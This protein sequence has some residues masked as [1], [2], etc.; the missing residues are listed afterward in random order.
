MTE[1]DGRGPL[2]VSAVLFGCLFAAQAAVIALSPVL[3]QVAS[4][5][6]VSTAAAGQLRMVLGLTAG[7][8]ALAAGRLGARYSLRRLLTTG[9]L[10]LAAGSAA[11]AAAPSFE[12]LALAQAAVGVAVAL[13]ASTATAAAA[14]WVQPSERARVLSWALTGQPAAWIVGMPLIGAL[15]SVSWRYGWLALPLVAAL[16]AAAA[17]AGH[18]ARTPPTGEAAPLSRV[19]AD[20]SVVAWTASELLVSAGWTA[21][22][23]YV[24]ALCAEADNASSAVIGFVLAAG[25]AA[26]VAGNFTF[27]RV[28]GAD[29]R[30][31]LTPLS[32]AL[33]GGVLLVATVRPTLAV[34]SALFAAAAFVGGGRMLLGNLFGLELAPANRLALTGVRAAATQFGYFIGSAAGGAALAAYGWN[35]FG[36]VAASLIALAPLPLAV[37]ARRDARPLRPRAEPL[38]P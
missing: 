3:P 6:D 9:A 36:V 4:D 28:A 2:A 17:V 16:A 35:G 31:L 27:R 34:T 21:T 19:F 14:D 5:L 1:R 7:V 20:S 25:A 38:R 12:A 11:S 23:V 24:G 18:G 30:A 26:F 8:T 13:L 32:F 29:P 33:A 37:V 10:L 15:G 22:L